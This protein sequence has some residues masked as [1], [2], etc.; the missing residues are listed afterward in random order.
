MKTLYNFLFILLVTTHIAFAQNKVI[1]GV[2]KDGNETVI[3]AT[4]QEKG[5][6]NNIAITDVDGKFT[7]MLEGS[8]KVIVIKSIGYIG[9]EVSVNK[10]STI[11]VQLEQD[12]KALQEVVVVGYG[13]QKKLTVSSS[14]SSVSGEEIRQTPSASLQNTLTGKITGFVSQQR[15]GQPGSDGAEFYIRGVSTFNGATTPLVLVDDIEYSYDQFSRIDANEVESITILKDASATAIYGIKGANGVILVTT[16]RGKAGDAKINFRSEFGVQAPTHVPQLLDAYQSALLRNQAIENDNRIYSTNVPPDFTEADLEHYRTGDDPYGHP[17]VNWYKTLFKPSAPMNTNNLDISGGSEKLKYFISTGFLNQGGILRD[18]S[19]GNDVNTGYNFKRYNF[20]SN[21]DIQATS[22]LSFKLD[23]TGNFGQTNSPNFTTGFNNGETGAF[24]EV[25]SY[26]WLR[27]SVYPIYNPDGSFGFTNPNGVAPALN[28]IIGRLKYGGFTVKRDNYINFNFAVNKT[29]N[30][31]LKGFSTRVSI[32]SSNSNRAVRSVSRADFPSFYYN[33]VDQS[34]T[35]RDANLYR[36]SPWVQTYD[37]GNPIQQTNIQGSLNYAGKFG[38]HNVSGLF[39]YNQNSSTTPSSNALQNYIPDNFRGYTM[40][41]GYNFNEK[42]L[43][44]ISGAYNGSD[45]F[46]HPYGLFPAVSVGWNVSEEKLIRDHLPFIELLKIRGSY[47]TVGSD[48]TGPFKYVYEQVY[49]QSGG[50]ISLGESDNRFTSIQET[51]LANENVSW[52][53]ERKSD[54]G[55]DFSF[56]KGKLSGTVEYFDNLRYDILARRQT[57]PSAYGITDAMKPPVNLGKVSNKGFEAEITQRG[58]LGTLGYSIKGIV[59]I[60][61]N[62]IVFEDEVDPKYPWKRQTGQSIGN[63]AEYVFDGFYTQEDINDPSVA[64]PAGIVGAGFLKYRDLNNDGIIN[65]DDMGYFGKPNIPQ[66]NLGLNFGL[67]FKGIS[68]SALLQSAR[69]YDV[70]PN[71][72]LIGPFSANL[73]AI[74]QRSWTPETATTAEFPVLVTN[75]GGTNMNPNGNESDFWTIS[76]NYIRLRSVELSYQLPSKFVSKIKLGSARIYANGYNLFSKSK[77]FE[78]YGFD[79]ELFRAPGTP[80]TNK[81]S[82]PV[83]AIFNFGF[84]ISLK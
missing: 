79:P 6:P 83:Q 27:P 60:A 44:Q 53:K 21:L 54:I 68:L 74:H 66:T 26:G 41:L 34:Y 58:K 73:Q 9:K 71:N 42:Y 84:N 55:V 69:D 2:I 57:I 46:T 67:D 18:F 45:R 22:S 11:N 24:T 36:I 50:A 15:S 40:R 39:L 20:R 49:D 76:G 59:S 75:I 8:S 33:P 32:A 25:M 61:K 17:D 70:R 35:P 81:V 31:L 12:T 43:L 62:K 14:I 16:R 77:S 80:L 37:A 56:F 64:K 28:N 78:K 13:T 51:L 10:N 82:Y 3:G 4:V 29:W 19:E 48:N 5:V 7:L 52:E 23:A 47:G 63:L 38:P 30:K 72:D 1:S 65:T